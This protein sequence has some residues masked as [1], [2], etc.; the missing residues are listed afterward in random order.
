MSWLRVEELFSKIKSNS[1]CDIEDLRGYYQAEQ[2]A[3]VICTKCSRRMKQS[4]RSQPMVKLF[5]CS[6]CDTSKK[7]QVI[8]AKFETNYSTLILLRILCYFTLN[9][10]NS[11]IS[12]ILELDRNSTNSIILQILG[13]IRNY[14][15][16]DK[17]GSANGIVQ[18][19]ESAIGKRKYNVGRTGNQTWIFGGIDME[20]KRF[21]CKLFLIAKLLL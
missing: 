4:P 15:E 10:S 18:L 14:L 16:K 9:I 6:R 2:D 21:L 8:K 19:D 1:I 5:R 3:E 11:V 12:E 17:L 20:T 7:I 13:D